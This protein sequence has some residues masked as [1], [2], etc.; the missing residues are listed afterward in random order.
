MMN[1]RFV[2]DNNILVSALLIKN[3]PPFQIIKLIESQ[4]LILYSEATLLELNRV[5]SRKKFERYFTLEE[6]QEF[7]LKLIEMSE[8]VEIKELITICRDPKD[9]KFLEL[10]ISG[11]ADF[12]ITGDQDL[13]ILNPFRDIEIITANEFL[14]RFN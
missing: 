11:K 6:K 12:I 8:L 13:L 2:L 10:A 5:L 4:G 9:D 1:K 7:I 3:S 14:T